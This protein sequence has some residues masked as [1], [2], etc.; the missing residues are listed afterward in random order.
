LALSRARLTPSGTRLVTPTDAELVRAAQADP[1]RFDA[2]YRRYL[3]TVYRYVRARVGSAGDAEDIVSA[4]FI[5]AMTSLPRY[6]EQGRFAAWMFTIARRRITAHRR[7]HFRR[8]G[9]EALVDE[10][11]LRRL[12][13]D[14]RGSGGASRMVERD[15][16]ERVMAAHLSEDQREALTLRFYGELPIAEIAKVMGKGESATKMLLH[17]GLNRLR[18][19]MADADDVPPPGGRA[20]G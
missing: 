3:P 5:E 10:E 11:S 20:D 9:R 12:P 8:E 6:R 17:R 14:S 4:A 7:R 15:R 19:A 2:V 16:L 1:A 13:D 18:A